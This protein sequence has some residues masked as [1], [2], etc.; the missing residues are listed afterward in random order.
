MAPLQRE[1]LKGMDPDVAPSF[2]KEGWGG[3]LFSPHPY[4][5]P[6]G[7]ERIKEWIPASALGSCTGVFW[8]LRFLGV[9]N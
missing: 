7:G 3:F 6:H 8:Y 1:G 9:K 5:L 2:V 4:L